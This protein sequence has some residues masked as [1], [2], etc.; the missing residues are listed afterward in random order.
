MAS[1]LFVNTLHVDFESVLTMEH[2]GMVRM[3]KS[4]KDTGLRGFLG[5][6]T[7]VFE[8][9][10]IEFFANS[11]VID[12]TIVS[13][14]CNRKLVIMEDMFSATFKLPIEGVTSI[15]GIPKETIAE[16]RRRF[17]ATDMPFKISSKKR[18]MSFENRLLHDI[19]AKSLCAKAG[20][21]DT[22]TCEKFEFMVAISAGLSV[23]W[24]RILFQQGYT[25]P[26]V[27]TNKSVQRYINKNQDIAPE[28]ETSKRAEDT[29]SNTDVSMPHQEEPTV[30][31]SLT[32]AKEKGIKTSNKRKQM[33]GGQKKQTKKVTKP[34]TQTVERQ[35]VH[36]RKEIRIKDISSFESLVK[37]EE[38]QLAWGET[39][40]VSE[41]V[42][43][44]S[45]ILYKLF[46][47]EV[48][49][50]YHEHLANFK[51]DAPSDEEVAF[52]EF[53][54]APPLALEFSSLAEQEQAAEQTGGQ[55]LDQPAN[56]NMTMIYPEHPT[57]VNE[58]HVQ[59]D[60][61]Q[62]EGNEHQAHDEHGC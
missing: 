4:L 9:A 18:E 19:V 17:S 26:K 7:Y 1:S 62:A 34:A 39:E 32:T 37:I 44:R 3:F 46:E 15:G 41:L 45:L 22:V 25:V 30:P 36:F 8:N 57:Q 48:E 58:P 27:F 12:G 28:G 61:H 11:K 13:T 5:G 51:L 14:V 56:D 42:E 43:R 35:S 40:E 55:Q 24:G 49:K 59:T 52:L 29:A 10:V 20:S 31:E 38:Q 6:T 53:A 2:I 23:N 50:V 16:M 54:S 47:M 60:G 21:F 33:D